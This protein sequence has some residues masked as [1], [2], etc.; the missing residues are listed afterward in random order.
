MLMEGN[1]VK[2]IREILNLVLKPG[3]SSWTLKSPK[4]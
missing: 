2:N 1:R 4:I 3:T